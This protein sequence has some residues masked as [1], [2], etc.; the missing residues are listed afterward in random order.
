MADEEKISKLQ[1]LVEDDPN[2]ALAHFSL[3]MALKDGGRAEEAV[4]HF[5]R[6][7]AVDSQH[8]KA[9]Q[10]LGMVQRD[11]GQTDLAV[12]TLTN[13]Y[14]VAERHGD[15]MPMK[16][17]GKLLEVLGAP[18]P[19]AAERDTV[20]STTPEAAAADGAF[21]CRRCSGSGPQLPRRPFKGVLGEEILATVCQGCWDEWVKMG[22]MV[23]NELRLPMHDPKAQDAYDEQMKEFLQIGQAEPTV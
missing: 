11:L 20:T 6:V 19:K 8:S 10:M 7:L 12:R 2:D 15:I 3:G 9:H 4:P 5:Q 14:R 23:I 16:A 13:G 22:T 21:S 1:A 17:M 18:V